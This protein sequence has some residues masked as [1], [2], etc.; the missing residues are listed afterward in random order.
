MF[1][2]LMDLLAGFA[3]INLLYGDD[4]DDTENDD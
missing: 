3:L 1:D 4:D 2:F